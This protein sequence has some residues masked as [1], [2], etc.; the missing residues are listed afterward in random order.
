MLITYLGNGGRGTPP[1]LS[2]HDYQRNTRRGESGRY[3]ELSLFGGTV[4]FYKD[5]AS[6]DTVVSETT[7]GCREVTLIPV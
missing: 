3:L 6:T 2:A 1:T 7:Q 4:E 5:T